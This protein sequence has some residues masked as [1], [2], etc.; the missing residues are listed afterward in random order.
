MTSKST[1]PV[2]ASKIFAVSASPQGPEAAT[3]AATSGASVR[4]PFS[5]W[6][7][8]ASHN[9]PHAMKRVH[10]RIDPSCPPQKAAA[11]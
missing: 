11:L 9:A 1:A 2:R 8:R 4:C 7:R 5:R 6:E 10:K 3:E